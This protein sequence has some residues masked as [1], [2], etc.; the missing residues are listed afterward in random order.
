MD[1]QELLKALKP[2]VILWISNFT[3]PQTVLDQQ[4]QSSELANCSIQFFIDTETNLLKVK[5]KYPD[6]TVKT[7]SISLS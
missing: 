1:F 4:L 6:G 5:A 2:I 3:G 7:G